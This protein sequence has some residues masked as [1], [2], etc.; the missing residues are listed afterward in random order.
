MQEVEVLRSAVAEFARRVGVIAEGQWGLPTPCEDWAVRDLVEHV[1]GGNRLAVALLD[2]ATSEQVVTRLRSREPTDNP[3]DEVRRTAATMLSAF[4]QSGALERICD[5]PADR[6]TGR[7]FAVY[8]VG[9]IV[10][11][12]WDLARA[13]GADEALDGDVV[14]AALDVYVPWVASLHIQDTF[15]PG[16]SGSMSA[17]ASRQLRLLD[18]LG[19]RP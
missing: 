1:I 11:H 9:D 18:A 2:G 8:R 14:E 17:D 7:A 10:V 6:I 4:S 5:H 16:P 12:A 19:R 3:G 15:G 13:I